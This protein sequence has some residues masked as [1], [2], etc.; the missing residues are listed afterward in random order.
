MRQYISVLQWQK[1]KTPITAEFCEMINEALNNN[2]SMTLR[3][4][5]E[6]LDEENK[7]ASVE[8]LER[9]EQEQFG[10]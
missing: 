1:E 3:E 9:I 5:A 8:R 6:L 2:P 10:N 7:R 4:F